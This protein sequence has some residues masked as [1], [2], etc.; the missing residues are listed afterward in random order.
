MIFFVFI[1]VLIVTPSFDATSQDKGDFDFSRTFL[2]ANRLFNQGKYEEAASLYELL[3]TKIE[4]GD[5]YY[6]LG[7]AY[8]KSGR[9]G[10][11]ILS[12]RNAQIYMPRN[13]DLKAN[14]E[15][16][17]QLTKDKIEKKT[18]Y[19]LLNTICFWYDDFNLREVFFS[20]LIANGIFWTIALL[21]IWFR[22]EFFYWS[23]LVSF[24]FLIVIGLTL[25]AKI[26]NTF[27]SKEGVITNKEVAVRSGNGL[28]NT[29]LF[30]L[31]EGA[32]FK[33]LSRNGSWIKIELPDGKKGWVQRKFVGIVGE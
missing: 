33:L 15:Y 7:N 12:Y 2:E 24:I 23:F 30:Y 26:Y 21:R 5:I 9:L 17:R 19:S 18:G 32:E 22:N 16:A 6:N 31:H 1:T 11:A 13:E 8:L 20:F 10:E 14:I 3:T 25:G 27:Y 28:N 4:N 29:V